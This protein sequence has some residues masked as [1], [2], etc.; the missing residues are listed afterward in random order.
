MTACQ[1][2][3]MVRV[4]IE[5]RL[6]DALDIVNVQMKTIEWLQTGDE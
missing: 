1:A 3:G 5:A 6:L 4:K 2:S